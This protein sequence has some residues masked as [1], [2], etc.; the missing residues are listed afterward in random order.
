MMYVDCRL[1]F[2]LVGGDGGGISRQLQV[3]LFVSCQMSSQLFF[4]HMM[5]AELGHGGQERWGLHTRG[6]RQTSFREDGGSHQMTIQKSNCGA[7]GLRPF[8]GAAVLRQFE[9]ELLKVHQKRHY[10]DELEI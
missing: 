9:T 10:M 8:W 3:G 6:H 7:R 4:V 1:D 5:S 2:V